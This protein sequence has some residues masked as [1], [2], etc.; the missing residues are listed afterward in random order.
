MTQ[1]TLE[2]LNITC[3]GN[4]GLNHGFRS[5]TCFWGH[6]RFRTGGKPLIPKK[7]PLFK[8]LSVRQTSYCFPPLPW[9]PGNSLEPGGQAKNYPWH[10]GSLASRVYITW[11]NMKQKWKINVSK[12]Q[13]IVIQHH[14]NIILLWCRVQQL[15]WRTI[16]L[17]F[18]RTCFYLSARWRRKS[19]RKIHHYNCKFWNKIF[20][21]RIISQTI[22]SV[23]QNA[24]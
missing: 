19:L 8:A 4:Q 18:Y 12:K 20:A 3:P 9:W 5:P 7:K 15:E 23:T 11:K 24:R 22:L 6:L 1:Q 14:P 17:I 13:D 16:T 2:T 10:P 21:Q